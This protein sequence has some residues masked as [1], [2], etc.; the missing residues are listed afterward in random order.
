MTLVGFYAGLFGVPFLINTLHS[1]GSKHL[2]TNS[3]CAPQGPKA[4][5]AISK[6][7]RAQWPPLPYFLSSVQSPEV[8]QMRGHLLITPHAHPPGS[9]LPAPGFG[10]WH[11]TIPQGPNQPVI[12]RELGGLSEPAQ[13]SIG[14]RLWILM[15]ALTALVKGCYANCCNKQTPAFQW[16]HTI[17]VYSLTYVLVKQVNP[18]SETLSSKWWFRD[19]GSFHLIT[20]PSPGA[21]EQSPSI[22]QRQEERRKTALI[23]LE[24]HRM[25]GAQLVKTDH[26]PQAVARG[27][28]KFSPSHFKNSAL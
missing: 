28:G 17:D 24:P 9:G 7:L 21:S 1:F 2:T 12:P 15:S 16:L 11:T 14:E 10:V 23:H 4:A 3:E 26:M 6:C 5:E 25:W 20:S 18:V 27:A 22:S 8:S 19:P 13:R